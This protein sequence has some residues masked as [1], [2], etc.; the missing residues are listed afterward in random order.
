MTRYRLDKEE[1]DGGGEG[2]RRRKK[3]REKVKVEAV[4]HTVKW[5]DTGGI[6][7]AI[8]GVQRDVEK[9]FCLHPGSRGATSKLKH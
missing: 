2:Y 1:E 7:A 3:V 5:P 6:K 8:C 4:K 9:K